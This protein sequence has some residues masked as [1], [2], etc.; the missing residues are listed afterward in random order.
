MA[1]TWTNKPPFGDFTG[2]KLT[3][4]KCCCPDLFKVNKNTAKSFRSELATCRVMSLPPFSLLPVFV[5]LW[6]SSFVVFSSSLSWFYWSASCFP[7]AGSA[8]MSTQSACEEREKNVLILPL[9]TLLPVFSLHPQPLS[10]S[11]KWGPCRG[12][13]RVR[14]AIPK[15]RNVL[16]WDC[17]SMAQGEGDSWKQRQSCVVGKMI[18]R[19]HLAG[20]YWSDVM[21]CCASGQSL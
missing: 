4:P 21:W 1:Q 5:F 17:V 15:S 19:H 11:S 18:D 3:L 13:W 12:R 7:D 14:R 10:L 8:T 2:L 20:R 6:H 16:T 9:S